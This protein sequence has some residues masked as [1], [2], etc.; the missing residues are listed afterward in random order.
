MLTG[1]TTYF[2]DKWLKVYK[3]EPNVE[4]L[5]TKIQNSS[6]RVQPHMVFFDTRKNDTIK[7]LATYWIPDCDIIVKVDLESRSLVTF[8]CLA[9][10][11]TK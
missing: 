4:E 3:T 9:D 2:K 1:Y 7:I 11:K 5:N 6:I 8:Y 10:L